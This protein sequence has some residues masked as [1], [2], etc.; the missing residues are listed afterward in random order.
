MR[1]RGIRPV[2]QSTKHYVTRTSGAVNAGTRTSMILAKAV[3]A[4]ASTN[5]YDVLGGSVV[6]AVYVE[7]WIR[8]NGGTGTGNQF[9]LIIEKVSSG[10]AS[11]T[12]SQMLNMMGYPNKKNVL[13]TSQGVLSGSDTPSIPIVRQWF[14][15]PKGKQ[16]M[17]IGDEITLSASATDQQMQVCGFS[18]YK[19]YR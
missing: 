13:Y 11:A 9:N 18:T 19:E 16:R 3:V 4:P 2:I 1:H 10:Q 14:L 17:G 5:T 12:Y 6:K 8:S 15:I 7:F